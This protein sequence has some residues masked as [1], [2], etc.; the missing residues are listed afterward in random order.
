MVHYNRRP[1]VPGHGGARSELTAGRL[2]P[3][4]KNKTTPTLSERRSKRQKRTTEAENQPKRAQRSGGSWRDRAPRRGGDAP[5]DIRQGAR[6]RF[7]SAW[8]AGWHYTRR[9][10][11]PGHGGVRECA[12]AGRLY[13]FIKNKTTPTLSKWRS[14]R[15]KRTTEAGTQRKR[16][17]P[18]W[19]VT[20]RQSPP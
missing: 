10:I 19:W 18:Q 17:Q 12:N 15:L 2:F 13:L 16:A 5:V 7:L 3:F 20:A 1:A 14:K 11:V 4:I 6:S 8:C 9:P